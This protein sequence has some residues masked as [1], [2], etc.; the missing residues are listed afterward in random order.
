MRSVNRKP[1]ALISDDVPYAVQWAL[2][3]LA[4]VERYTSSNREV[5]ANGQK[6]VIVTRPEHLLAMEVSDYKDIGGNKRPASWYHDMCR[7]AKQRMR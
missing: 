4:P 1:I 5:I 7:L 2:V 6:Y 3:N